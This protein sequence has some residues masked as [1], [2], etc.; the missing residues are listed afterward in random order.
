[1]SIL[2]KGMD[3]PEDG[4]YAINLHIKDGKAVVRKIDGFGAYDAIEI[5]T[6][7]DTEQ[8]IFL[9]AISRE[10]EV[11]RK[12]DAEWGEGDPECEINLVHTCHEIERKVKGVLWT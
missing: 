9:K 5:P 6:L 10:E 4:T 3:M 12:V 11:C 8:R 1:M 2:I 7:T